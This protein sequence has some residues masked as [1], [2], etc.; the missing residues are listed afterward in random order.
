MDDRIYSMKDMTGR[1]VDAAYAADTASLP[2]VLLGNRWTTESPIQQPSN[3]GGPAWLPLAAYGTGLA[4]GNSGRQWGI[5][6][7]LTPNVNSIPME[8][9]MRFAGRGPLSETEPLWSTHIQED[10]TPQELLP[11]L[12]WGPTKS[13]LEGITE[14]IQDR[15][16]ER[17]ANQSFTSGWNKGQVDPS[18]YRTPYVNQATDPIY[19]NRVAINADTST[20]EQELARFEAELAAKVFQ[21]ALPYAT[22]VVA[23]H[24]IPGYDRMVNEGYDSWSP[25]DAVDTRSDWQKWK[26]SFKEDWKAK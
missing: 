15:N 20:L 14:A 1:M 3:S 22:G 10:T 8:G 6:D 4:L 13:H 21:D 5:A 17:D 24:E 11:S 23:S 7:A 25:S 2:E 9:P 19:Q 16:L 26:D 12:S 18:F